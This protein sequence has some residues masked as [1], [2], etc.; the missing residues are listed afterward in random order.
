MSV[1]AFVK[2]MGCGNSLQAFLWCISTE[3]NF[4]KTNYH[5]YFLSFEPS[6]KLNRLYICLLLKVFQSRPFLL[7]CKQPTTTIRW[8]SVLKRLSTVWKKKTISCKRLVG[9]RQ[10]KW[11]N[12]KFQICIHVLQM[13]QVCVWSKE[14][15]VSLKIRICIT[16]VIS[17]LFYET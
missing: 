6:C 12:P 1:I 17:V 5:V 7:Q 8:A 10:A 13:T 2:D 16:L 14:L 3:Q 15:V 9:E 11:E 4:I